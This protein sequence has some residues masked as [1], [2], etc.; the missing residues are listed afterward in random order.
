MIETLVNGTWHPAV[1]PQPAGSPG[2][3]GGF[4]AW[5][6]CPAPGSCVTVGGYYTH[7]GPAAD[8]SQ[9]QI[10]TPAGGIWTA[11]PGALPADAGTKDQIGALY[12]V[13]CTQ[14]GNCVSMGIYAAGANTR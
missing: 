9:P 6:A 7:T 3:F 4:L 1:T 8:A 5:V 10:D 14:T 11:T 2:P 12:D 13:A